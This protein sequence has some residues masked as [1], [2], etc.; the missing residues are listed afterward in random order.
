MDKK[1]MENKIQS[2]ESKITR[3]EINRIKMYNEYRNSQELVTLLEL[4]IAELD[5]ECFEVNSQ[6]F[7][8]KADCFMLRE[9]MDSLL[10]TLSENMREGVCE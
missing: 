2:L 10:D 1:D 4:Q 8:S 5:R 9:S 6:L 3:L 7:D